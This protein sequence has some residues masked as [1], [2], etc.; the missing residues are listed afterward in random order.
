MGMVVVAHKFEENTSYLKAVWI[1]RIFMDRFRFFLLELYSNTAEY[2]IM[3]LC[4]LHYINS[5][6]T[7][8]FWFID[9]DSKWKDVSEWS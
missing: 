5:N 8:W 9:N 3:V 7:H 6:L 4:I 1:D 2:C